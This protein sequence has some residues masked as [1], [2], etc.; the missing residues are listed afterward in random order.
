VLGYAQQAFWACRRQCGSNAALTLFDRKVD[1]VRVEEMAG[2]T[3]LEPAASCVTGRRSN[4]LNYAPAWNTL[5]IV[6]SDITRFP[7]VSSRSLRFHLTV[8]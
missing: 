1:V 8:P 7:L 5:I 6:P 3:G 2:A 4:Q